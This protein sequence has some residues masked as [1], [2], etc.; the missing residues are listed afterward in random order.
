M[1]NEEDMSSD[2]TGNQTQERSLQITTKGNHS[3]EG[4]VQ[5][6]HRSITHTAGQWK[7]VERS[8]RMEG[9]I[10]ERGGRKGGEKGN[11][12]RKIT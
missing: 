4:T 1:K 8:F 10:G 2:K 11:W 12:N 9:K 5:Q 6:A 7:S 3:R